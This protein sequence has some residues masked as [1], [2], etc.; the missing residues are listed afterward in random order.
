MSHIMIGLIYALEGVFAV[1]VIGSAIVLILTTI[2][3]TKT[4]LSKGDEHH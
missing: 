4:L 1:G 3:D 2:E